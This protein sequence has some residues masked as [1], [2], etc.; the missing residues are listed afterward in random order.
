MVLYVLESTFSRGFE[1]YLRSHSFVELAGNPPKESGS[2]KGH[3]SL[4]NGFRGGFAARLALR[5]LLF[6]LFGTSSDEFHQ[7]LLNPPL[8]GHSQIAVNIRSGL[9]VGCGSARK[10]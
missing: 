1:S 9:E 6:L 5:H 2:D 7:A 10:G 3:V 4:L 8:C